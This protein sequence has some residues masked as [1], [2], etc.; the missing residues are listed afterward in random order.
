MSE[1]PVQFFA[2]NGTTFVPTS[3]MAS[4][5]HNILPRGVYDVKY[6]QNIGFFYAAKTDRK[7]LPPKVYGNIQF[8]AERILATYLDRRD[9]LGK[10]TGVLLDGDK[11]SGKTLLAMMLMELAPMPTV[12][13]S[14]PFAGADFTNLLVQGGPK[15][16][17]LDEF[18]KV[19]QK[20]EAQNSLLSLLDGHHAT[21]NLTVATINDQSK[22]VDAMKNRPSRFFYRWS[23]KGL[24]EEFIKDFVAD[25]LENKA[26]VIRTIEEIKNIGDINFDC[27]NSVIEDMN[28]WG[29][30]AHVVLQHLNVKPNRSSMEY[31]LTLTHANEARATA[32][33]PLPELV[34]TTTRLAGYLAAVPYLHLDI[35]PFDLYLRG[36]E[37]DDEGEEAKLPDTIENDTSLGEVKTD[38][39]FVTFCRA[40][41]GEYKLT[42]TPMQNTYRF[43]AF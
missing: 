4:Q 14:E 27:L 32:G 39:S 6:D 3:E 24:G 28:R 1:R 30:P 23:Y 8:K 18:E 21:L 15:M 25:R 19:Y 29:E 35:K 22:L 2:Q 26:L 38:G 5:R 13:V 20:E 16:I 12:I 31:K 40:A 7:P 10:A 43:N 11:G 9:R 34:D 17:L 41:S 37:K 33:D 36:P 42:G